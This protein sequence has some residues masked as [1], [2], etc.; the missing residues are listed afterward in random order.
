[1]LFFNESD[2]FGFKVHTG[3]EEVREFHE[4]AFLVESAN[5]EEGAFMAIEIT[6]NDAHLAAIHGGGD[7]A[8]E[9][10]NRIF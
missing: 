9:I 8:R 5:F 1:M 10:V 7:F 3:R 6:S 4:D 2:K